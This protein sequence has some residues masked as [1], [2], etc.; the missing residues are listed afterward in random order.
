MFAVC[1]TFTIKPGAMPEFLPMMFDQAR[2]SLEIEPDCH[3]FDIC[4]SEEENAVFL[5]EIYTDAQAFQ[6]HRELDHTRTFEKV[7]PAYFDEKIVRTY[8]VADPD[9]DLALAGQGT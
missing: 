2:R 9:A 4:V 1:V 8:R 5:Y 7:S 3:Q 6:T